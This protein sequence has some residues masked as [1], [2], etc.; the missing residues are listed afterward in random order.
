MVCSG[1]VS[2][3][4]R[5]ELGTRRTRLGSTRGRYRQPA[6][7]AASAPGFEGKSRRGLHQAGLG[8]DPLKSGGGEGDRVCKSPSSGRGVGG[9]AEKPV[10]TGKRVC[11]AA[12]TLGLYSHFRNLFI[13]A[14]PT[15]PGPA[16]LDLSG[17]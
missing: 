6:G 4:T 1:C 2:A 13:I 11:P 5:C 16:R 8:G 9:T 17:P 10:P 15:R 7:A 3:T 12:L 14:A